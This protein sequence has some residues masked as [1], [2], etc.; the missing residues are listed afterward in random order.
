[1]T[2]REGLARAPTFSGGLSVGEWWA[3]AYLAGQEAGSHQPAA[4]FVLHNVIT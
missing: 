3:A 1:V 4:H 2:S